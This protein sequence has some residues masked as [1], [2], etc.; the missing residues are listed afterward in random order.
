MV[1]LGVMPILAG[2]PAALPPNLREATVKSSELP[3]TVDELV[4]YAEEQS[5]L[6]SAAA[7]ENIIVAMDHGLGK[8]PRAFELI[9]RGAR[10][11]AW[12]TEEFADKGRRA[13]YA[14]KGVDYAKRAIEIDPK[15]VEGHYYLG[16]NLGQS[17]TTKTVGAY[18]MVAKVVKA[19]QAAMKIDERF[20]HA[21]PPR[22]VGAVYAKA[23]PWPA[24]MGDI[25]EGIKY[26]SRAVVLA[27]EY[28]QNHLFYGDALV[29]DSK[30]NEA[31]REYKLVL[32][33]QVPAEWAHRAEKWR[34]DAEA[35]LKKVTEQRTETKHFRAPRVA[36]RALVSQ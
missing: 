4:R 12:L 15:R 10:A 6:E 29:S 13:S 21:G 16:I 8:E 27:P 17:A 26:L 18:M 34:H 33:A 1:A 23:P 35:G 9:W 7:A 30:L 19:G 11:C 20:D 24:S 32:A 22:L 25:D 31:E 14:Q 28:P 5:K 3:G 2:C 36:G